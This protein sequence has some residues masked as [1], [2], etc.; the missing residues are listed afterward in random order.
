VVSK[1]LVITCFLLLVL[2]SSLFSVQ[3]ELT[4]DPAEAKSIAREAYIFAYPMLENYR[5]MYLQLLSWGEPNEFTHI[6]QLYGPKNTMIVRPNN[7][8]VYSMVWMDL[9]VEPIVI[10]IPEIRNRYFAFQLV[11]M[12][13]HNLDYIGARTTGPGPTTFM[14]A[15]PKWEGEIP[16]GIA[17]VVF[18]EGNFVYCVVR[19]GVNSELEGDLQKVLKIQQQYKSQTL[20]NYCGNSV[21]EES[22]TVDLPPFDQAVADS[23]GFIGYFN[24]LLG[25]LEIHPSEKDLIQGFSK[26][27]IGPDYPFDPTSFSEP[28]REAIEA[29]IVEA[30]DEIY[31]ME[32]KI[33]TIQDGWSLPERIFG[34]RERMQ[35]LYLMRAAAAHLGLYGNDLEETFYPN[36]LF[37]GDGETLDASKYNYVIVFSKDQLPPVDPRGFWSLTMYNEG[38]QFVENPLNR[39]SI[40]DRSKLKYGEDGSLILYL[41]HESP[42]ASKESNWLPTP[43]GEFKLT[44]RIYIPLPEGLDPLYCPP[45]VQKAGAFGE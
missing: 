12:Y 40:G 21:M 22:H 27:G 3:P 7:D 2:I 34:N 5:T 24:F 32:T 8:T 29:A 33:G 16:S 25:Q 6:K 4:L 37:D 41:Q 14:V 20:S 30:R 11:D 39:Y 1:R 43:D 9:T 36:C 19:T 44:M 13:T 31:A 35:G 10:S 15:G 18:S 17:K 28:V 42:G 23:I 38:Q 45:P 26:I